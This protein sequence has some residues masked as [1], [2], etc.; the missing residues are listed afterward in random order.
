MEFK[1]IKKKVGNQ[2]LFEYQVLDSEGKIIGKRTTERT[3]VA[4]G[5]TS[6]PNKSGDA[7][8]YIVRNWFGRKDLIGKGESSRYF[9]KPGSYIA[10][11][12]EDLPQDKG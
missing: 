9:G 6:H 10:E 1:I 11:L 12:N 7:P 4:C 2:G 8:Q 5:I 3:Y